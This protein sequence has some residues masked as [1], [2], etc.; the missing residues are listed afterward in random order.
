MKWLFL[1]GACLFAVLILALYDP[2][3]EA[4]YGLDNAWNR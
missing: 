3:P 2:L 1:M 4:A